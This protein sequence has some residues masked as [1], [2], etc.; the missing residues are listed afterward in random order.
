M[1]PLCSPVAFINAIR[2][3]LGNEEGIKQEPLPEQTLMLEA[4]VAISAGVY[5]IHR[6]SDKILKH[7]SV[8]SGSDTTSTAL[9]N[10]FYYLLTNPDVYHRLRKEIDDAFPRE[11][12]KLDSVALTKLPYLNAVMCASLIRR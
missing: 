10:T 4:I 6:F 7:S 11:V 8:T 2:S 1:P 12:Q 5:F 3:Q 9:S